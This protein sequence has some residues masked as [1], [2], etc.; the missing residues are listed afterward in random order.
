MV[1]SLDYRLCFPCVEQS[2]SQSEPPNVCQ[3]ICSS[4]DKTEINSA[5]HFCK[6]TVWR[7]DDEDVTAS[8]LALPVMYCHVVSCLCP[9]PSPCLPLLVVVRLPFLPRF[10]PAVPCLL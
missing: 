9:F 10:P 7:M 5:V 6:G 3:M 4:L 1:N 2:P 8:C